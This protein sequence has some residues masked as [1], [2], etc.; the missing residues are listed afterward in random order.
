MAYLERELCN[1]FNSFIHLFLFSEIWENTSVK[2]KAMK[3][4][5]LP[6][7]LPALLPRITKGMDPVIYLF[8]T[9]SS[10]S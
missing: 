9:V 3:G 1:K 8:L 2:G 4:G 5:S 6:F 7:L 10:N